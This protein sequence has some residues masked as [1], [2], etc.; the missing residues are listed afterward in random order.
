MKI[1]G[2]FKVR[3]KG[4]MKIAIIQMV[5]TSSVVL[6]AGSSDIREQG[7]KLESKKEEEDC[8]D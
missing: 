5:C 6:K 8:E 1:G 7:G 2:N 3:G 4:N